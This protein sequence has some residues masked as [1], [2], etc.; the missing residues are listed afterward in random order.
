MPIVRTPEALRYGSH[1][2]YPANTPSLPLPRSI[3]QDYM[4][5]LYEIHDMLLTNQ[6]HVIL[7]MVQITVYCKCCASCRKR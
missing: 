1:S 2:F 6:F 4:Y 3:Y 7:Q 5:I